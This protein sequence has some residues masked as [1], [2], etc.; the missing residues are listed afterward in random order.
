MQTGS[1]P[2]ADLTPAEQEAIAREDDADAN[3]SPEFVTDDE[4]FG[5]NDEADERLVDAAMREYGLDGV[6]TLPEVGEDLVDV[7]EEDTT[8]R[9]LRH[10]GDPTAEEYEAHRVDHL[11]YRSWCPHC[12]NGKAT[13]RPHKPRTADRDSVPQLGFDYLHG[14]ES[15]ALASGEEEII[16]I[17]VAKCHSSKCI[18]AHV[19]PQK[20]LPLTN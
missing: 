8:K 1:T 20:G 5:P 3:L 16:K 19:V 12:V 18:F 11:P 4:L 7:E 14:S 13:S 2:V 10:P 6:E 9:V 17:L 15:L